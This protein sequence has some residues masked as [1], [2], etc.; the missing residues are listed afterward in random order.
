MQQRGATPKCANTC[1][2]FG[3]GDVFAAQVCLVCAQIRPIDSLRS[4]NTEALNQHELVLQVA[5]Q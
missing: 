4:S 3:S 5:L 1:L 2:Q